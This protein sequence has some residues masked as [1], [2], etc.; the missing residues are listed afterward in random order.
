ME[1]TIKKT[2]GQPSRTQ[3]GAKDYMITLSDGRS[4]LAE[5]SGSAK[6]LCNGVKG[7]LKQI[8]EMLVEPS[9][10]WDSEDGIVESLVPNPSNGNVWRSEPAALLAL[11][12]CQ[13]T[14]DSVSIEW[15]KDCLDCHGYLLENGEIDT[16]AAEAQ[17]NTLY[18]DRVWDLVEQMK[19]EGF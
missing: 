15:I 2:V 16:E 9:S 19:S 4:Y 17:V 13:N 18:Q 5:K 8:K 6:Y 11:M 12:A 3:P 14:R 7:T 10:D 1:L